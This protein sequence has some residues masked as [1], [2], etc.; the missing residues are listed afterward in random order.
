MKPSRAQMSAENNLRYGTMSRF[1]ALKSMTI[2]VEESSLVVYL[3][4][5]YGHC[6]LLL[7]NL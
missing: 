3:K 5:N 2:F 4:A 7:M 1:I 6:W